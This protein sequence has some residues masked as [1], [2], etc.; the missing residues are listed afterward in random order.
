MTTKTTTKKSTG[1]H[2]SLARAEPTPSNCQ[3]VIIIE[4]G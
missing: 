1:L 3:S 4:Q 2:V